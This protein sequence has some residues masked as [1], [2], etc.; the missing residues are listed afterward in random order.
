MTIGAVFGWVWLGLFIVSGILFVVFG[1]V[2]VRRLR[3]DPATRHHL[4][5][6]LCSGWDIVNAA[7]ALSWPAPPKRRPEHGAQSDLHAN[8]EIL[9]Q[10]TSRLDRILGRAYYATMVSSFLWIAL[11]GFVGNWVK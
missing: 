7:V 8:K 10:H 1:E 11:Y 4:G 3:K 5:F 9:L 2:T 6:E